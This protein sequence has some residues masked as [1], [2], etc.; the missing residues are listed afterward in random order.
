[1][2]N[3]VVDDYNTMGFKLPTDDWFANDLKDFFMDT[4]LS[5]KFRERGIYNLKI[6]DNAVKEHMTKK[7]NH[8]LLMWQALNFELWA[9]KWKPEF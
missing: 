1:M 7:K 6:F 5:K 9:L 8:M 3:N 4:I 2:P